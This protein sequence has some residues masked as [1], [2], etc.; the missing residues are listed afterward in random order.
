M[1]SDKCYEVVVKHRH[2]GVLHIASFNTVEQAN[3]YL[4][5]CWENLRIERYLSQINYGGAIYDK[6]NSGKRIVIL[7]P[8]YL[9]KNAFNNLNGTG[10]VC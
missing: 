5:V 6:H 10:G 8:D 4:R 7:G 9:T 3:A 1:E 2:H